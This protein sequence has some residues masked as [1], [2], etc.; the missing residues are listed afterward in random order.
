MSAEPIL[1]IKDL[2]IALPASGERALAV[3]SLNLEVFPGEIL[4]VVGESGSGKS[5]TAFASIGLLAK[6]LEPTNG[7]IR[8]GGD[9]ILSMSER[10]LQNVRGKQVG[11]VFQEPMTALN[12][13]FTVGNQIEEM[14]W[15]HQPEMSSRARRN[16]VLSILEEVQLPDPPALINAYPRQLSGGQRQ[17][18]VIAMAMALSPKLL[19]ADEPTTALDVTTQARILDLIKDLRKNHEAGILFITHDFGVVAEVAD[20]VIVMEKGRLVEQGTVAK[21]I[22]NPQHPYTQELV[23]A[24]PR[25]RSTI[26]DHGAPDGETPL[27]SARNIRKTFS[28]KRGMFRKIRRVD[29]VKGFDLDLHS[30]ES[31]AIVGESGSGKSTVANCMLRLQE[32]D[33]GT[34]R[35]N[36][37][38]FFALSREDLRNARRDIQIVFQ[39][40]Y[41]SLNPRKSIRDTLLQGPRNFGISDEISLKLAKEI[42]D[43]VQ[44]D[45]NTLNRFPNQFSGGQRQRICIARALMLEPKILIAD[46]AV[47][48]LDVSIQAEVLRLLADIRRRLNLT[49]LFITHDLRVASQV[50]DRVIVM[51]YGEVI[52]EG[53]I[54][55][56]FKTP[57]HAYT[58]MLLDATLGKNLPIEPVAEWFDHE[59]DLSSTV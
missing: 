58:R 54:V 32:A 51:R 43:I 38:D 5:V 27:L 18:I 30:G 16:K 33:A 53:S 55:D 4:C 20:R 37:R 41:G 13:S 36:G 28:T 26:E 3:E 17:R 15:R 47:S 57:Q 12:P 25:M 1:S 59:R 56:V 44:L 14:F 7:Y 29:A 2:S 9:D 19:I 39:D 52:E 50:C 35:I 21:V 46:E 49:I 31:L 23:A 45:K 8:L 22:G 42:L 24:I 6:V 11:M 48:A 34:M 40:P 10:E